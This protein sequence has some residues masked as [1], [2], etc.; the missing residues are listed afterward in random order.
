MK[1][2]HIIAA[3]VFLAVTTFCGLRAT[4]ADKNFTLLFADKLATTEGIA[5]CPD[6]TLFTVENATGAVW[7]IIS[8]TEL[9]PY[10]KGPEL[11]RPAG[12][13][14]GY[15]NTLYALDYPTGRLVALIKGDKGVEARV[16]T[17]KLTTP[18]AAAPLKD[19]SL[20]VS[21]TD[22]GR[23]S[24]VGKDGAVTTLVTGIQYAN[25]IA[26][27]DD[28]TVAWVNATTP[29][30]IFM[31]PLAKDLRGKKKVFVTGVQMVDGIARAADGS[32]YVCLYATGKIAHVS[33]DGATTTIIAEGLTS[34]AS[35][36]IRNDAL[37]VT[38]LTGKG[39]YKVPLPAE[40]TK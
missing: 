16:V 19:G 22:K 6:G 1:T 27:N 4:A 32:F 35:P 25:G 20:L 15:D 28:E 3:I 10:W 33:P 8:D 11:T 12:L 34:P 2:K 23:V 14:C 29:G 31:V 40:E 26:V 36:L 9:E 24:I 39:I 13:A 37:Y 38:S 21:E 18:N 5:A 17:D 7:R 30:K